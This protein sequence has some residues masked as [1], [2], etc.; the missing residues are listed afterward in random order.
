MEVPKVPYVPKTYT[1]GSEL[2]IVPQLCFRWL[3]EMR[4]IPMTP[5]ADG[6]LPLLRGEVPGS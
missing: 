2:A 1:G 5:A 4:A 6:L 3:L